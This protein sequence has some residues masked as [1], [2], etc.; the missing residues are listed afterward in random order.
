MKFISPRTDYAFKK[1]FGSEN[2]KEILISFLNAIL[3]F[4]NENK[5][6]NLNILDPFNLPMK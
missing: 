6:I 3:D 1:I 4:K 5:I 2:S